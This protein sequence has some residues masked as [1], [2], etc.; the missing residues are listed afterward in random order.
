MS[1]TNSTNSSNSTNPPNPNFNRPTVTVSN[2]DPRCRLCGHNRSKCSICQTPRSHSSAADR[3]KAKKVLK[4]RRKAYCCKCKHKSKLVRFFDPNHKEK[5]ALI[6]YT[7]LKIDAAARLRSYILEALKSKQ[8]QSSRTTCG[9]FSRMNTRHDDQG[10]PGTG[11]PSLLVF[12]C[13]IPDHINVAASD[14]LEH[15]VMQVENIVLR[16]ILLLSNE[17]PI[18]TGI[19]R[20]ILRTLF[21]QLATLTHRAFPALM[22][23][24]LMNRKAFQHSLHVAGRGVQTGYKELWATALQTGLLRCSRGI[25]ESAGGLGELETLSTEF[26][27]RSIVPS[28]DAGVQLLLWKSRALA[29][30]LRF[31]LAPLRAGRS[32]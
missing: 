14:L 28:H 20:T 3:R 10:S 26:G 21:N 13:Q 15:R 29:D 16:L 6:K 32:F 25:V 5:V 17:G 8:Y 19:L 9:G 4:T 2:N 1:P 12:N 24:V 18:D 22:P 7:E 31:W 23:E 11:G 30:E 27:G